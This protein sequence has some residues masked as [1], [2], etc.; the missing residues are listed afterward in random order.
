MVASSGRTRAEEVQMR[1]TRAGLGVA[2]VPLLSG[3]MMMGGWGHTA[4]V[5][6]HPTGHMVSGERI[7][8]SRR[9]EASSDGLTITLSVA[10]PT[11][12]APVTIGAW[13]RSD[14]D[15]GAPTDSEIRLRI[16]SP[17]G[18]VDRFRMHEP[19]SPGDGAYRAE[20]TLATSGTYVVTADARSGTGSDARTV[21]VTTDVV[22]G[23]DPWHDQHHCLMP[24]VGGVGMLALMA[25]MMAG[26]TH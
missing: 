7:V 25:V 5:G 13:L 17:D 14:D 6:V 8:S 4:A 26:M 16:R 21:S 23:D 10:A 2:A 1:M 18:T 24:V 20:Y 12:G 11:G 19:R 15:D 3:C 9:A 22:A